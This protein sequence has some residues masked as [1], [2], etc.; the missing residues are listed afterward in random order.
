MDILPFVRYS[1]Y[2][3]D[4]AHNT[5]NLDA[6]VSFRIP[7][8]SEV[9]K[10][11]KVLSA[12]QDVVAFEQQLLESQTTN[13][14]YLVFHDLEIYNENILGEFNRM[15]NLKK[16][17]S[18]RTDSYQNVDGEYSRIHRLLEY[19]A[20]LKSWESLLEYSY[21]RDQLLLDLQ[22]YLLTEPIGNYIEFTELK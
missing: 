17:L 8:S 2:N 1:Y 11:R 6:G 9:S 5:Y 21:R 15:K 20:Y 16:F 13:G 3:R 4:N 12:Q 7:L 22:R 19:N 18:M 10:K 14:I